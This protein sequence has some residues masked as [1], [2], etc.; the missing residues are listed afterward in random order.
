MPA[1]LCRED[2]PKNAVPYNLVYAADTLGRRVSPKHCRD[3]DGV[4]S[5]TGKFAVTIVA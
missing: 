5:Y 2:I 1:S 3:L 4:I